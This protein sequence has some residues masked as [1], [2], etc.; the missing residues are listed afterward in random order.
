M[1]NIVITGVSTGIGY[2][3]AKRLINHEYRVFGSVRNTEDAEKLQ[4]EFGDNFHP[5]IFDVVNKNQIDKA[6]KPKV[7][8][9][10][11]GH[12]VIEH[13][14][15]M[16]VVDVNSGRFIGKKEHEENSL[17]VNLYISATE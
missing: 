4:I 11:G 12:L 13:T 16:V 15:A 7:W 9:K 8:L 5:I 17:K 6:L 10:S 1:K 2:S 14:E 3:S